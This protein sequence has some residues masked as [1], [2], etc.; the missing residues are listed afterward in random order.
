MTAPTSTFALA[1]AT[2]EN[3]AIDRAR[4]AFISSDVSLS[5]GTSPRAVATIH[6]EHGRI[7]VVY[8]TATPED[9][10]AARPVISS[11]SL[12]LRLKSQRVFSRLV[13]VCWR[14]PDI[15]THR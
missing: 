10:E 4:P 2:S 9:C 5:E 15:S 8:V 6:Q 12:S 3:E 1:F 11:V 14:H 7:P 13:P